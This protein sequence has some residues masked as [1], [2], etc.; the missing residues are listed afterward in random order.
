MYWRNTQ[1]LGKRVRLRGLLNL[2]KFQWSLNKH[3]VVDGA[4]S[5][6]LIISLV[7]R[8]ERVRFHVGI[9]MVFLERM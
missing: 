5:D 4:K 1:N 9:V 7:A 6:W 8:K 2:Y 3:L